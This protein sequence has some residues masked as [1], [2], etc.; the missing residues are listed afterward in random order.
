LAGAKAG[1]ETGASLADGAFVGDRV[2]LTGTFGAIV[3]AWMEG[4]VGTCGAAIGIETGAGAG[5]I[6]GAARN[7]LA[8]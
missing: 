6:I 8:Y 3:G 2:G 4:P 1:A 7:Q 5:T